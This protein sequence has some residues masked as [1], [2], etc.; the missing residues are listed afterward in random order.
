MTKV[1]L[2]FSFLLFVL[3]S[4]SAQAQMT[5]CTDPVTKKITLIQGGVCPSASMRQEVLNVPKN[6]GITPGTTSQTTMVRSSSNASAHVSTLR[7]CKR[8]CPNNASICLE[9]Y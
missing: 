5:R 2:L 1:K 3:I 7:H 4:L 9:W 6:S 8:R